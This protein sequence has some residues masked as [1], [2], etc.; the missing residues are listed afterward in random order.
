[1]P[2]LSPATH[3]S[4]PTESPWE[5]VPP[6][7]AATWTAQAANP[8]TDSRPSLDTFEGFQAALV[9][10]VTERDADSMAALMADEFTI[11]YWLSESQTYTPG[12]APSV[13]LQYALPE[14]ELACTEQPADLEDTLAIFGVDLNRMW[15][16][17]ANI[18]GTSYCTG[19][20]ENQDGAAL[21]FIAQN[22]DG[23]YYWYSTLLA[24][25][26]F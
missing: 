26:G 17:G 16:D 8:P 23:S 5:P 19:W 22:E 25:N 7:V 12:E 13:L 9:K 6:E 20:G 21:M 10:A 4:R 11:A 2:Q 18:V 15:V 3:R 24:N 1:M 14:A